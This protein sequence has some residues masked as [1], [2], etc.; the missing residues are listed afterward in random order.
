M[1][2]RPALSR[3][4]DASFLNSVANNAD[5]RPW[6]GGNGVLDLAPT[7]ADFRNFGLVTDAGGFVLTAHGPGVYE[8]HSM[9]LPSAGAAAIAAM[10]AGMGYMFTRT[11]CFQ[12]LTK[13]PDDNRAA[14]GLARA[15][16]FRLAFHRPDCW[17][18]GGVK[19]FAQ[20]VEDW[21]LGNA[22][23][24]A[25]GEWFHATLEAAKL[26]TGSDLPTHPHDAAHD[27]I[28]G[29]TVQMMRAGNVAKAAFFYNRWARF[30][31]YG[32]IQ[33]LNQT[34]AV[35]DLGDAVVELRDGNM[36]MLTCR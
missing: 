28:V 20:T 24:E 23:L 5:V 12:L 2:A 35:L 17:N 31:G 6:L 18:G 3:T 16:G 9:F 21:A 30:A 19:H 34:P 27:R 15:G 13:V 32:P 1:V 29:A 10:R 22:A 4:V 33:L 26:A 7:L 36:E 8:V 14:L 11:D 25:D